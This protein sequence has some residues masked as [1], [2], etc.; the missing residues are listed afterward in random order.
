MIFKIGTI[1]IVMSGAQ[2]CVD[3]Y[4]GTTWT[5]EFLQQFGSLPLLVPDARK[6]LYSNALNGCFGSS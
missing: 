3:N 1:K 4:D 6:L 5:V 2:A